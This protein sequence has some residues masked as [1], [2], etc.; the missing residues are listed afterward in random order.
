MT[1]LKDMEGFVYQKGFPRA[2]DISRASSLAT[3]HTG[4]RG[5]NIDVSALTPDFESS[6]NDERWGLW[7]IHN[8]VLSS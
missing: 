6:I 8:M 5:D 1:L 3:L 4:N 2:A 7:W